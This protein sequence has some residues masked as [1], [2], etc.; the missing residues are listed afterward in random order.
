MNKASSGERKGESWN[1]AW[2]QPIPFDPPDTG[3]PQVIASSGHSNSLSHK[4]FLLK[5]IMSILSLEAR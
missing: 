3:L 2:A 4:V 1:R 5:P